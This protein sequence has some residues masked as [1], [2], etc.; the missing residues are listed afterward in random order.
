[1]LTR[2]LQA[3]TCGTLAATAL[4][5]PVLGQLTER[6][7]RS[8]LWPTSP[9]ERPS[10]EAVLEA[11]TSL[12]ALTRAEMD[13]LTEWMRRG[14]TLP[15]I[16]GSAN[17]LTELV[18]AAPGAR[19]IPVVVRLPSTYT[20]ER[21]WPLIL[22][23]HGGPTGSVAGALRGALGMIAVWSQPAEDAGWIVAAPAMVD[24]VARDG[25]TQERLPYE[26]FHPEEARAVIGAVR[27]RV[28]VDPDR[29]VST[30]IS[31]GS[32]FSIAYA[33]A[34]P[35]WF[36]A[37][38]PVS[39]EGESRE[40]LLRNLGYVPTY[41]LEGAQDRNIR[42]INGPRAM[43]AIMQRFGYDW[44]YREFSEQAHEGFQEHYPDVLR[45]LADRPRQLFPQEVLRVP[46]S[47]IVPPARRVHWIESDTRQALVHARVAGPTEID[48]R[49]R[50][51][52]EV[53]LYLSDGLVDLDREIA[54]RLNGEP[55]FEGAL[56]RSARVALAEARRLGDPARVYATRLTLRVPDT[57]GARSVARTLTE[58]LE[59]RHPEGPLSFWEMYA[60][61]A[62]EERFP[63]VG[64]EG[65]EVSLEGGVATAPEQVGLR[66]ERVAPDGPPA[67][68]GLRPGD[69]LLTIGGEPFFQGRGQI[70]R[71]HHWLVRELRETPNEY[72]LV[73]L[74]S[75]R[76][77]ELRAPY[78]L[79]PYRPPPR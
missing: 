66:V 29:I 39:T 76:R 45:W 24:V 19:E 52:G 12:S 42:A 38:V 50:W 57:P 75:G 32:N 67:E 55:V 1:V 33:A 47:G 31:L 35:D 13:S 18:V 4:P 11:D 70:A 7:V 41:V 68:A 49:A 3:L 28:A 64:F 16:S 51:A 59:P 25:R 22:A 37:I 78:A 43:D 34:H 56:A 15:T 65:S 9:A 5:A 20:P 58:E 72:E 10:A 6:L 36:S 77:V 63:S 54:V 17:T 46:H 69:V 48:V 53:T 30:G 40:W 44:V 79:G 73:V 71:L 2:V 23:M 60:V 27:T 8:Y 62:L 61:R 21:K 26:I 14:P 74:R